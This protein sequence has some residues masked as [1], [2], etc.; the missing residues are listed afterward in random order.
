MCVSSLVLSPVRC[1]EINCF[2]SSRCSSSA[3]PIGPLLQ[4][5]QTRQTHQTS[6]S[7]HFQLSQLVSGLGRILSI[8]R[9]LC[10]SR[11]VVKPRCL[12]CSSFLF[13]PCVFFLFPLPFS[14]PI[15][16]F[17]CASVLVLV[18]RLRPTCSLV[19]LLSPVI[20]LFSAADRVFSIFPFA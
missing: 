18:A 8:Q 12:S 4:T 5:R 3:N 16:F 2:N 14:F 1:L 20:R 11:F 9:S 7:C 6:Y 19:T 15:F 13:S 10:S 17:S